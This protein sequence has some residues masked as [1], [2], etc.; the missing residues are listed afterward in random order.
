MRRKLLRAKEKD[1]APGEIR[2]PELLLRRTCHKIN[3]QLSAICIDLHYV[4][5]ITDFRLQSTTETSQ[6]KPTLDTELGTVGSTPAGEDSPPILPD[7]GSPR[8]DCTSRPDTGNKLD[9]RRSG[10]EPPWAGTEAPTLQLMVASQLSPYNLVHVGGAFCKPQSTIGAHRNTLWAALGGRKREF[11]DFS[12]GG[13][14]PKYPISSNRP[15]RI[16]RSQSYPIRR[17]VARYG[18]MFD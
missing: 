3:E 15:H 8:P 5:S 16:V 7:R 13:D 6:H 17:A 10:T 2:T 9:H 4:G 12:L 11:G 1:G 18:V 14:S